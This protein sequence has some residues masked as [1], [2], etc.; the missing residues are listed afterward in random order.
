[1]IG[2]IAESDADGRVVQE[3]VKRLVAS[4]R[5]SVRI[6]VKGYG[7]CDKMCSKAARDLRALSREGT[8][9]FVICH[10]ADQNDAAAIVNKVRS[11]IV[12]PSG[13]LIEKCCI[14]VPIQEIEAWLIADEVA[15]RKTIPSF[16]FDGHPNPESIAQPKEYLETASH[17]RSRPK[18]IP[19]IHNP[20]V[21]SHLRLEHVQRKCRSFHTFVGQLRA[22]LKLKHR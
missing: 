21:A 1:M 2:I 3:I 20:V 6:R 5:L 10:D 16:Q 13:V 14:A 8:T 22:L 4:E 19:S 9:K 12:E 17:T 11:L 7:G 18:Y 15:I